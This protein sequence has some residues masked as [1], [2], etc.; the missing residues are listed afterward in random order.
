MKKDC[1][2]RARTVDGASQKAEQPVAID[3]DEGPKFW[4]INRLNEL[5]SSD[6]GFKQVDWLFFQANQLVNVL[7][8]HE[9]AIER[10][11]VDADRDTPWEVV[12]DS[13]LENTLHT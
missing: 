11:E 10:S 4:R 1:V 7:A 2:W 12:D 3:K 9:F 6:H 13:I 8:D 5:I